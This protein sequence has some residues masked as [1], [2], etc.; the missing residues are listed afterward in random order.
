[1]SEHC[2]ILLSLWTNKSYL[3]TANCVRVPMKK[4][5]RAKKRLT[6]KICA[7]SD[8]FPSIQIAF[9][10]FYVQINMVLLGDAI[11]WNVFFHF[12]VHR[13]CRLRLNKSSMVMSNSNQDCH[14]YFIW[15]C[16]FIVKHNKHWDERRREKISL[17]Q[18]RVTFQEILSTK[19]I[20][21]IVLDHLWNRSVVPLS[22]HHFKFLDRTDTGTL[23]RTLYGKKNSCFCLIFIT[24]GLWFI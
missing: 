18:N 22:L 21:W 14:L 20:V 23:F 12:F 9:N 17:L 1:M 2:D 10:I 4:K 6:M 24:F 13:Y 8:F 16:S 5:E 11:H 7:R 15:C 3:S 19:W